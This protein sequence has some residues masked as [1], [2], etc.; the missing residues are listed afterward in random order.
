MTDGVRAATAGDPA[1]DEKRE[2]LYGKYDNNGLDTGFRLQGQ[3]F[4]NR[5]EELDEMIA[6]LETST[7]D[8]G[9][10]AWN[11]PAT[12]LRSM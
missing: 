5:V 4:L 6:L 7:S 2:E 3:H 12:R 9:A 10:A 8:T 11:S 1:K